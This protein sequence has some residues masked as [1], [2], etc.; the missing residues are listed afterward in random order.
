MTSTISSR[1]RPAP[2]VETLTAQ[3]SELLKEFYAGEQKRT[4]L[5]HTI[6]SVVVDIR[7]R[8]K[9]ADGTPDWAGRSR[10]YRAAIAKMYSEAGIPAD[11]VA[12]VQ[13]ALRYHIGNELRQR[14]T[15]EQLQ[16]AGLGQRGPRDRA[17]TAAGAAAQ[18]SA[19]GANQRTPEQHM[20]LALDS[21]NRAL[22]LPVPTEERSVRTLSEILVLLRNATLR[23][24]E[25]LAVSLQAFEPLTVG[26]AIEAATAKKA[27]AKRTAATSRT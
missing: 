5:L 16:A 24:G 12:G 8:F 2:T 4:Q 15:P 6:A 22:L 14:L 27:P 9:S 11:S 18:R 23:Y 10:D 13:A 26:G 20:R 7:S 17:P 25:L 19:S 21:V 3:G 1:T